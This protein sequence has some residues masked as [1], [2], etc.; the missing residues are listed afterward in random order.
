MPIIFAL[1]GGEGCPRSFRLLPG[2][3]GEV[4]KSVSLGIWPWQIPPVCPVFDRGARKEQSMKRSFSFTL[5]TSAALLCLL[6]SAAAVWSQT[7]TSGINGTITDPQGKP[8]P[9]AKV[10]ITNVATNATRTM[11]ATETGTYVFDLITPGDYRIEVEA[12]GFKKAV[13]EN[14]RALI[15]KETGAD[16]HMEVGELAQVV[17]VSLSAQAAVMNTQDASLGNVLDTNQ[18]SQLPLEGRNLGDL[19]SL[20]PGSTREGYVTGSRADQSNV[21]LDGVDINNAQTGNA[22]DATNNQIVGGLGND[23]SD[24]TN[25]PVL[26]LNAE[27]VEEFRVTTANGNADQGRSAGAQVN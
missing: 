14:V 26:R 25:G 4:S 21:T 12:K 2:V 23:K 8:I 13:V 3:S 27:A 24:I 5:V 10:T 6:L 7:G 9:G 18:F 16:V 17:E 11:K 19:L 20:Q 22:S 15:G 1:S